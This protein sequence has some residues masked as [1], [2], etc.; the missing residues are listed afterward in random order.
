MGCNLRGLNLPFDQ[1]LVAVRGP[2]G[3]AADPYEVKFRRIKMVASKKNELASVVAEFGRHDLI[4]VKE[5]RDEI[6][7]FERE[8]YD[9]LLTQSV[10]NQDSHLVI[11]HKAREF[12][13]SSMPDNA[14]AKWSNMGFCDILHEVLQFI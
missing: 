1:V 9:A 3:V 12:P 2:L 11:I 14:T 8:F 13:P 10:R 6:Q 4:I 7:A 5:M